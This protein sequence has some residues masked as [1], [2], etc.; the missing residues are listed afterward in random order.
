MNIK[1]IT[2]IAKNRGIKTGKLNKLSLIRTIQIKEGNFDCYGTAY[3]GG[4]DQQQ[5]SWRTDCLGQTK[6]VK[7]RTKS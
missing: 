6:Q 3:G 2:S 1:E 4:C 5:C 7:Q